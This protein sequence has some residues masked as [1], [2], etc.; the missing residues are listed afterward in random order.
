MVVTSGRHDA[1]VKF[2]IIKMVVQF[3]KFCYKSVNLYADIMMLVLCQYNCTLCHILLNLFLHV[4]KDDSMMQKDIDIMSFTNI[5]VITRI[6]RFYLSSVF[7][8][9]KTCLRTSCQGMSRCDIFTFES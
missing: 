5:D 9:P 6:L 8:H 3:T 2:Q 7:L 4:G 1:D